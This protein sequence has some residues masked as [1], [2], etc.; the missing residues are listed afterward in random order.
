MRES[1]FI[2]KNEA[3]W[4]ELEVMI[5]G[6]KAD[7]ERLEELFTKV[8]GDLSYA[9]TFFSRRSVRVY[10]NDLVN[11]VF[12]KMRT[13]RKY[14]IKDRILRFYAHTVP[15]I[16]VYHRKAFFLS[17][18]VF[19][20]SV[21]IGVFS[22]LMDISFAREILGDLYIRMTEMNIRNDDPMAVYKSA[23]EA[24][25]F[26]GILLN[27]VRVA[28]LTFILGVFTAFGSI[29]VLI[30]NGIMVGVFQSFFYIKGLFLTSFLTIWIHGTIEISSIVIAGAAGI[31]LGNSLL[32]R[33]SYTAGVAL[34]NAAVKALFILFSTVPLF[35]IAAFLEGYVTRQTGMPTFLK[36][37]IIL[38]SL[39]F[40][41]FIYVYLP[42]RHYWKYGIQEPHYVSTEN[43]KKNIVEYTSVIERSTVTFSQ[44]IGTLFMKV[45]LP[46]SF[47]IW[48]GMYALLKLNI[49]LFD[50]QVVYDIFTYK[51]IY[52]I[53]PFLIGVILLM[54]FITRTMDIVS[55]GDGRISSTVKRILINPFP[56]FVLSVSIFLAIIFIPIK[57]LWLGI[58]F[59]PI[60]AFASTIKNI[61]F[62]QKP[63]ISILME[64]IGDSYRYFFQILVK[65]III[66]AILLA[67]FLLTSNAMVGYFF[68][69]FL[70]LF[71]FFELEHVQ[72][73]FVG[74]V[75]STPF[76]IL[77]IIYMMIL[78]PNE[79]YKQKRFRTATDLMEKINEFG[80]ERKI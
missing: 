6:K 63:S 42:L 25:M 16:V 43:N 53:W 80:I 37:A 45:I 30:R 33:G 47:L 10:L 9:R 49:E 27:N 78:L 75:V 52:F 29:F 55:T 64:E 74:L 59:F 70:S 50:R 28:F 61:S 69:G 1:D 39:A 22:T 14:K 76:F 21:G 20:V 62:G 32:F 38:S 19:L 13:R 23:N 46:F 66:I 41:L 77:V 26:L 3:S 12:D 7:P 24:N 8:A 5:R 67:I 57:Y 58:V 73:M 35:F 65:K 40:V 71:S 54:F 48:V 36:V 79:L 15:A 34:R 2:K 11:R 4:D 56:V 31:I 72:S 44:N 60:A 18:I 51:T 68:Q 17:L